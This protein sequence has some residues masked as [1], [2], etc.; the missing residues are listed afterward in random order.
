MLASCASKKISTPSSTANKNTKSNIGADELYYTADKARIQGDYTKAKQNFEAYLKLN[1][2]NAA[3][4]YFYGNIIIKEG[5]KVNGLSHIKQAYDLDSKNKVYAEAYATALIY[6][7]KIADGTSLLVKL[8]D[9]NR[10]LSEDYL[11]KALYYLEQTNNLNKALEITEKLEKNHGFSEDVSNRKIRILDK[12]KNNAGIITELQKL[13]EFDPNESKYYIAK[14]ELHKELKQQKEVDA[15]YNILETKFEHN[16]EAINTL[17]RNALVNKDMVTYEKYLAKAITNNNIDALSKL[18]LLWP[19]IKLAQTD[20]SLQPQVLARF[21]NIYESAGSNNKVSL[22][23]ANVLAEFNKPTEALPIFKKA[24]DQDKNN[25]DAWQSVISIYLT[26]NQNDSA[27]EIAK[28]ALSYYPNQGVLYL[29]KGQA[30]M[31]L[32]KNQNAIA[33]YN[34]GLELVS[35]NPSLVQTFYSSLGDIYNTTKQYKLSDSCFETAIKLNPNN[36]SSLNNY[37]YFL[38]LRNEQLE[39]AASMSQKSLQLVPNEKHF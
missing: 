23:Y 33:D 37:A 21:K 30:N 39:K 29:Y 11:Y 31:L 28:R 1:N 32:Q 24:L 14:L 10:A 27:L 6:N 25:L 13:I 36:A 15:L 12:Q 8:A 16:A 26:L 3:A 19:S 9:E 35:E 22:A 34:T 20:S 38:S 17:L 18:E 5:Q 4:H 7:D 2:S